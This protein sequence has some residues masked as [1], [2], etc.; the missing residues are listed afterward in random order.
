MQSKN[1]PVLSVL[2]TVYNA[3]TYLQ[4]SLDSLSMQ[5]FKDF[6]VIVL[7][8]GSTDRSRE[9]LRTWGDPRLKLFEKAEN[10]GRTKALNFCLSS[11]KCEYIAILDSDDLA[12][13]LRFLSQI[14][15]LETNPNIGLVA[16]WAKYIDQAGV[17]YTTHEP[18]MEHQEIVKLMGKKNPFTHSSVCFRRELAIEVGNYDEKFN[19]AQDYKLYADLLNITNF[20]V[21]SDYHCSWRNEPTSLTNRNDLTVERILEEGLILREIGQKDL[22]KGI[23]LIANQLKRIAVRLILFRRLLLDGRVL[24]LACSLLSLKKIPKIQASRE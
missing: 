3:G 20:A 21:L 7:E 19:Y 9:I 11:A 24:I 4:E 14:K 23:D 15:F 18:P 6:E 1:I 22:L 16:T 5:V 10:I 8:H 13:P 12:G 2:M 17:V